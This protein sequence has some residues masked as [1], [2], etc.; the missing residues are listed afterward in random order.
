MAVASAAGVKPR[1]GLRARMEYSAGSPPP[2]R[3]DRFRRRVL[4]KPRRLR[5][6]NRSVAVSVA[7]LVE[8]QTVDLDVAGSNP[9]AHPTFLHYRP[10]HA[11]APLAAH[12][13]A[14]NTV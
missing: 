13:A 4:Q 2:R 7:Q 9:V 1:A 5:A 10:R 12:A 11:Q 3:V 8:L 6:R 14:Y